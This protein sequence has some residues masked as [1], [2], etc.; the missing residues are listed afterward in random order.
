[1]SSEDETDDPTNQLVQAHREAHQLVGE[2]MAAIR[3]LSEKTGGTS[4]TSVIWAAEMLSSGWRRY[5]IAIAPPDEAP[6][7]LKEHFA[8]LRKLGSHCGKDVED[9]LLQ[10]VSVDNDSNDLHDIDPTLLVPGGDA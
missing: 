1:M 5:R 6:E 10:E 3:A 8:L 9:F 4:P 7:E 2:F